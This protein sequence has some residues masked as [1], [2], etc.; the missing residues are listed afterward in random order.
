MK[1]KEIIELIKK[2]IGI[3]A[4]PA[5]AI[6]ALFGRDITEFVSLTVAMLISILEWVAYFFKDSNGKLHIVNVLHKLI[7]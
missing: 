6:A 2:I 5:I 1:P 7:S 3:L 4:A